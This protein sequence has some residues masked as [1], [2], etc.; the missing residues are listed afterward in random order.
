MSEIR[1]R[2]PGIPS[3]EFG[4]RW[5]ATFGKN[6][7]RAG[8]ASILEPPACLACGHDSG[9]GAVIGFDWT[10]RDGRTLECRCSRCGAV[11]RCSER[12]ESWVVE[13]QG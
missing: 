12:D 10:P 7:E 5:E 3:D 4:D 1:T 6:A 2:P 13:E 11:Y 9:L 8:R